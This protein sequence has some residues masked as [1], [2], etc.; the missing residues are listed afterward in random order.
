MIERKIFLESRSSV[1]RHDAA[2]KLF[3]QLA[4]LQQQQ[5]RI[6]KMV[7]PKQKAILFHMETRSGARRRE[8]ADAQNL[9]DR[10]LLTP[11]QAKAAQQKDV[12]MQNKELPVRPSSTRP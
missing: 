5:F 4:K 10:D 6:S 1:E 8:E 11:A 2:K 12:P 3:D 9:R 7:K